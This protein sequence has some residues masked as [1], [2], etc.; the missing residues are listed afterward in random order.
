MFDFQNFNFIWY[1]QK[2]LK[3]LDL[4]GQS[5][6][7]IRIFLIRINYFSCYWPMVISLIKL[8]QLWVIYQNC[9]NAYLHLQFVYLSLLNCE[10]LCYYGK[11][12]QSSR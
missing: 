8:G 11:P 5:S 10:I 7:L 2:Q 12:M 1:L 3:V 9:S 4:I 6:V